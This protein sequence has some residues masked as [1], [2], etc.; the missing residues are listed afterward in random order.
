MSTPGFLVVRH[1]PVLQIPVTQDSNDRSGRLP[2][3]CSDDTLASGYVTGGTIT[4]AEQGEGELYGNHVERREAFLPTSANRSWIDLDNP[5]PA[6]VIERFY[7]YVHNVTT[8]D[9][10]SQR[11]RLQVWRQVDITLKTFRLIWLQLI[12]VSA[13]YSIGALYSVCDPQLIIEPFAFFWPRNTVKL[14]RHIML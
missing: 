7:I 12:Q 4:F 13:G 11:I 9:P 5:L 10:Q 8:L 1:F 3:S 6:G 2:T 14:V